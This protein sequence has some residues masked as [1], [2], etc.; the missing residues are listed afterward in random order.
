LLLRSDNGGEFLA[1]SVRRWLAEAGDETACIA[2]GSPWENAYVESFNGKVRDQ[3]Q[4]REIF[5]SLTE[6]KMLARN[7]REHYNHRRPHSALGYLTPAEFAAAKLA[8]GS[9]TL[10]LRQ[11]ARQSQPDA[12]ISTG[13]LFGGPVR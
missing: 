8:S 13:T 5:T 4:G 10:R 11:A 6:A 3:L 1:R 12:L 9:A 7:Y 2:P